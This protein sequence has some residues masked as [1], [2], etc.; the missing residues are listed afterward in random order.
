MGKVRKI[1]KKIWRGVKK[2][3][4]K[5]GKAFNRVFKGVG[6]F[7][8]KLGPIGTLAMIIAMPYIG[9]YL[10]QGFG[11]WAGGLSGN[12]GKI[13]NGVYKAGN[14]LHGVYK[15]ITDAVYGTLSKIPIVGDALQGFDRFLDKTRAWVGLEPGAMNVM[16]DKELNA[17]ANTEAGATA[18]GFDNIDTFKTSNPTF[19]NTDNTLNKAGLDFTRGHGMA[20]EAHLRGK[21]IYKKIDGEFQFG[22]DNFSD[23]F[24]SVLGDDRFGSSISKFGEGLAGKDS[25]FLR[26][27]TSGAMQERQASFKEHLDSLSVEDRRKFYKVGESGKSPFTEWNESFVASTKF[28]SPKGLFD[29]PTSSDTYFEGV[30]SRFT[31]DKPIKDKDGNIIG[32]KTEEGTRFGRATKEAAKESLAVVAGGGEEVD[33][34]YAYQRYYPEVAEAAL[35]EPAGTALPSIGLPNTTI[36][37]GYMNLLG[38]GGTLTGAKLEQL[39]NAGLYM[40]HIQN[41]LPLGHYNV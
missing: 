20:Y 39:I 33:D 26:T 13:M 17:W 24:N 38:Q 6:K 30:D 31:Y 4:K 27:G 19:F 40:P 7:L 34:P 37:L 3:G 1:G 41:E 10:W 5:I 11:S 8:G 35:L 23:N 21:D 28:E 15:N 12:F 32:Y 18:M 29:K 22:A 9:S 14:S 36:Q 25:V 16:N 2:L